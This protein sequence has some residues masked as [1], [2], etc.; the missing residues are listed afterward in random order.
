MTN[1]QL[2]K[3][4]ETVDWNAT[5]TCDLCRKQDTG[6]YVQ[7][8]PPQSEYSALCSDCITELNNEYRRK[9]KEQLAKEARCQVNSCKARGT[10]KVGS[11]NPVLMCRRHYNKAN[12]NMQKAVG[13]MFYLA[14]GMTG[15]DA[16]QFAQN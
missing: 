5:Y 16:L 12:A 14:W 6:Y 3:W 13:G 1:K 8:Q 2:Q 10:L 9:R 11:Y 15:Q 4:A 7:P